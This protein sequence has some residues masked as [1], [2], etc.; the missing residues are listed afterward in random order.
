MYYRHF[1]LT[2]P[3]F[4]ALA[5]PEALYLSQAHRE[6]LAALEW[7]L[8]HEPSGFTTLTGETGTG[9]TT[10][11]SSIL[12]RN[13]AQLRAAYV[14][15]PKLSF[16]D[17]L[18]VVLGQF[19]IPC[20]EPNKLDRIEAL[21]SFLGARTPNE[22]LAIIVDE[23][24]DLS[25]DVLEELRLLSNYGQRIGKYLQ[26]VLV[27][28]PELALRLK[29]PSLRQ[30][31]QRVAARSVLNRLSFVEAH[32]YVGYRL[33]A[34]DGR[35]RDIFDSEALD[36]L[37]RHSAG[38]PRQINVLC[39]NAML[40]AYS[41]GAPLVDLKSARAAVAE[42][43]GSLLGG[44]WTL[45]IP[46][47]GV[48]SIYVGIAALALLLFAGYGYRPVPTRAP[49]TNADILAAAPAQAAGIIGNASINV[50]RESKAAFKAM[51]KATI[52]TVAK[53]IVPEL[54]F[55][56]VKRAVAGTSSENGS[57]G[58]PHT[59]PAIATSTAANARQENA[60]SREQDTAN[61]VL[62]AALTAQPAMKQEDTQ[63]EKSPKEVT[64]DDRKVRP[65]V[66]KSDLS[67]EQAV[68]HQRSILVKYGDTLEKLALRYLGSRY[69]LNEIIDDNPQIMDINRI[70]PGQKVYLS[71]SGHTGADTTPGSVAAHSSASFADSSR[72][73]D[74][75]IPGSASAARND[76][77]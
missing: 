47:K 21:V 77:R 12:A 1:R 75:A 54:A 46:S 38:I 57:P 51:A 59:S 69:A 61:L 72:I 64:D 50:A 53:Q 23:A 11:V 40:L 29:N 26:L 19:G 63:Q 34:R 4:E 60:K 73:D 5:G 70:Y 9:K 32:E 55:P 65:P 27:G 14:I 2:G 71:R 39:H 3:P 44:P 62:P 33:R 45:T 35:S 20:M 22:R 42:H 25:D 10:L 8:L 37:L 36:Y 7:G 52:K 15:N 48:Q 58:T 49:L 74:S 43:G 67:V 31:N 66:H 17:I 13:F 30:F 18:R 6:S 28:Q 16:E 68:D 41:A 76:S 24:Q 56:P